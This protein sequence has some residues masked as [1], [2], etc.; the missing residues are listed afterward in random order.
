MGRKYYTCCSTYLGEFF[1]SNRIGQIV[2]SGTAVFFG[3][4]NSHHIIPGHLFHCL[5][6]ESFSCI[7]LCRKRLHD[8]FTE[9]LQKR[10]NHFLLFSQAKIHKCFLLYFGANIPRKT[11]LF[12]FKFRVNISLVD[13]EL[14]LYSPKLLLCIQHSNSPLIKICVY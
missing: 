6:R 5:S 8:L 7:N 13:I 11:F 2:P 3:K 9:F 14:A 10:P 12:S 1:N 4:W